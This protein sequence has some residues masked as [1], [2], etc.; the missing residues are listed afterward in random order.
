MLKYTYLLIYVSHNKDIGGSKIKV[1]DL[2][3]GTKDPSYKLLE[4]QG[5]HVIK[6]ALMDKNHLMWMD[7]ILN[8]SSAE[9][10]VNGKKTFL[11]PVN[12]WIM[13]NQDRDTL[14]KNKS[15]ILAN[16]QGMR[17]HISSNNYLHIGKFY[18]KIFKDHDLDLETHA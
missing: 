16:H 13:A 9:I 18:F 17:M 11:G 12:E 3:H 2:H 8:I 7:V 4:V 10:K 6:T 1:V 5:N 15:F 14:L